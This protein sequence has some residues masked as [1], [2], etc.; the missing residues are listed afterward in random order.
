MACVSTNIVKANLLA[1]A[2]DDRGTVK[3]ICRF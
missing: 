1:P 2:A 3:S